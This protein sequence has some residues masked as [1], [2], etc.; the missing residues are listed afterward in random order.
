MTTS[1]WGVFM[2]FLK[3]LERFS[4]VTDDKEKK[5]PLTVLYCVKFTK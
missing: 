3:I 2:E 4:G 1:V 5:L